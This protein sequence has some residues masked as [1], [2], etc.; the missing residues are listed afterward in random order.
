[1]RATNRAFGI[2]LALVLLTRA[3]AGSATEIAVCTDF[4]PFTIELFDKDAPLHTAN[5][6]R[7]VDD[8]FYSGT[9]FHRVVGGF[10]VQGGGYDRELRRRETL[11]PIEN[12]SRNGLSNV[13]G[14]LAAARTSDPNS[15]TSQFFI[16]LVDNARL[17][18]TDKEWGYTVFGRVKAGM[19]IVDKIGQLPT[20]SAGALGADVPDP[21]VAVSSMTVLD[22]KAL[23]K[24]PEES[25]P[26]TLVKRI[27]E[28]L[29]ANEPEQTLAWVRLYR[30]LCAPLLPDV[31]L[32]EAKSASALGQMR[33]ARYA[34]EDY[35]AFAD[36][37]H[38]TYA[39]AKALYATLAPG[40]Q[41]G[42]KPLTGQ[43]KVPEI[44]NIP[45]GS[46]DSL[47]VMVDGQTAIRKFMSESETYLECLSEII[48]DHDLDDEQHSAAVREHNQMVGVMEDVAEDFNK[49][50]RIFKAREQ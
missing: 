50:V 19:E 35:F 24:L 29:A 21:L 11:D 27:F 42:V 7:Y 33:H 14:T 31:L 16:N 36:A 18:A 47:D 32:A 26:E 6:L 28:A 25:R 49:Q 4:G 44:P 30:S 48:D 40:T 23:D 34:L 38:P 9:V 37:S 46:I 43:C 3:T 1:M 22:T 41:P 8:G 45:N 13:R 2:S 10:V 17:N 39:S 20:S 12:E 15:A 5:F